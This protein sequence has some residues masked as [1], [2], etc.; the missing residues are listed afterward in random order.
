MENSKISWT[1]HTFNPWR[2]CV[3]VSP[4]CQHCYAETLSRRWGQDIWGVDKPRVIASDAYW[5]QPAKWNRE[6]EAAGERRRVFCASLADVFEDRPDL[7]E[8]RRRLF[9]LI[10][11]TPHLD[12]LLLT[13]RP[14]NIVPL[15]RRIPIL[16][17]DNLWEHLWLAHDGE[18]YLRHFPNVW[19]GTTAEDQQRADERIPHLLRVPAS[20]H[21]L[22]CEPLLGAVNLQIARAEPCMRRSYLEYNQR[23]KDGKFSDATY[24]RVDWV[25]C[26]GESGPSAPTMK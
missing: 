9:N 11:D 26:G 14:Q 23:I 13:K 2:G 1:H 4:G 25:I 10:M 15:M 22:S 16:K 12:W 8:P 18:G 7:D 3:K 19:L 20:V 24:N 21:F 6:A 17:R 5:K